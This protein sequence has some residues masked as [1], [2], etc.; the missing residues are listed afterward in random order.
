STA[1]IIL[2]RPEGAAE[3]PSAISKGG[4][5][6]QVTG[7]TVTKSCRFCKKEGHVM[8]DCPTRPKKDKKAEAAKSTA[9]VNKAKRLR[10]DAGSGPSAAQQAPQ[11]VI[12]L[13]TRPP[14][15]ATAAP[16]PARPVSIL[17]AATA[18]AHTPAQPTPVVLQAARAAPAARAQSVPSVAPAQ[19]TAPAAQVAPPAAR[20]DVGI[21]HPLPTQPASG[22]RVSVAS[23]AVAAAA[24]DVCSPVPTAAEVAVSIS[25]APSAT[26]AANSQPFQMPETHRQEAPTT[27]DNGSQAAPEAAT[28]ATEPADSDEEMEENSG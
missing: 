17:S 8:D 6:I 27:N 14:V 11:N 2:E 16:A 15:P 24:A 20:T 18:T 23:L 7:E 9:A 1:A 3:I 25:S 10:G 19:Q 28:P 5:S 12:P 26:Q 4:Y 13:A 22:R 21:P